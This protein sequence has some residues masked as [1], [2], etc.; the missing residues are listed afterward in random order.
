MAER[1]M[2]ISFDCGTT[3]LGVCVHIF[4]KAPILELRDKLAELL[5]ELKSINANNSTNNNNTSNNKE[6]SNNNHTPINTNNSTNNNTNSNFTSAAIVN[7]VAAANKLADDFFRLAHIDLVTAKTAGGLK[8]YLARLDSNIIIPFVGQKIVLIEKQFVAS[9]KSCIVSHYLAYHYA[10]NEV[11]SSYNT[12]WTP[13]L[14]REIEV[15]MVGASLKN[16]QDFDKTVTYGD[17]CTKYKTNYAANKAHSVAQFQYILG[18]FGHTK[19]LERFRGKKLPDIADA[20]MMSVAWTLK[21]L[22]QCAI[23]KNAVG[24]L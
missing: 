23:H 4:D 14:R 16:V 17:C 2:I 9:S 12:S 19:S 8:T 10:D 20:Y 1:A 5:C 7:N 11:F 13:F 24:F 18:K 21:R 6:Q 15:Q 22:R 3:N